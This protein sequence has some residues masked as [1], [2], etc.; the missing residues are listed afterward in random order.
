MRK[1]LA[2]FLV[3]ACGVR[4]QAQ[5]AAIPD[6]GRIVILSDRVGPSI[7]PAERTKFYLFP[8]ILNYRNAVVLQLP[9]S[10]FRV[11]FTVGREN[12]PPRDTLAVYSYAILCRMAERI[13]HREEIET[14][15]YQPGVNPPPLWSATA[16]AVQLRTPKPPG[17]PKNVGTLPLAPAEGY[18]YPRYFPAIH[19]GLGM[20]TFNPDFSGLAAALQKTPS[21]GVSPLMTGLV[22][23]AIIEAISIQAEGGVSIGGEESFQGSIGAVYYL[24][25]NSTRSVRL[26]AGAAFFG[27]NFSALLSGIRVD[28]GQSGFCGTA[29]VEI[30][31]N[32]AAAVDLYG[33][34]CPLPTVSTIFYDYQRS[35]QSAQAVPASVKFSSLL[36]GL[37]IS[38]L[39]RSHQLG[40]RR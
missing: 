27:W 22:E 8:S 25:L 35:P 37:R 3:C 19:I 29:G 17:F 6:S 12:E 15:R 7:D 38:S 2:L 28:G 39:S 16:A 33:G 5:D 23:I 32:Q 9:D 1:L 11:R 30:H 26:F 31:V 10:S 40:V 36:L 4:L 20:R 14:G 34:Y 18:P 24:P 21:L 13:D